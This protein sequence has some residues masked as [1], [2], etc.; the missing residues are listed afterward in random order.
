[1]DSPLALAP[2]TA[3]QYRPE[4]EATRAYAI[5]RRFSIAYSDSLILITERGRHSFS[6]SGRITGMPYLSAYLSMD[7]HG[8]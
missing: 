7:T 2:R 1:M 5:D 4:T 6:L 3:S 8:A